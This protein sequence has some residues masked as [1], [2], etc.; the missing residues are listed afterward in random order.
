MRGPAGDT[1]KLPL[2]RSILGCAREKETQAQ[3]SQGSYGGWSLAYV[4]YPSPS[5]GR[6]PWEFPSWLSSNESN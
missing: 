2:A 3:G 6:P 1:G 5:M 4:I